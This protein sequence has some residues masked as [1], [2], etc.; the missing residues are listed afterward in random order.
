MHI[1]DGFLDTKT[2]VSLDVVSLGAVSYAVRKTSEALEEKSVPMMGVMAAFIFAAQ[3]LNFPVLGGT[4]GHLLGATLAVVMLGPWPAVLVMTAIFVIQALFFQDGG[5][6]ALGA[7]V[8]N[9]AVVAPV[10]AYYIYL[11]IKRVV[12]GDKGILVGVFVA[13][14]VTVVLAAALTAIELAISGTMSLL[15]ALT[16]MISVHTVIGLGE[17]M[18]ATTIVAFVLQVRR[19]IV[20]GAEPTTPVKRDL[21]A[22]AR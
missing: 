7:N 21:G 4:S 14:W 6:L 16:S 20:P 2:W 10:T 22:E 3:M 19:D 13:S 17:A 8:F 9:M 12:S 18:I 15:I 11:I 5:L 1:P